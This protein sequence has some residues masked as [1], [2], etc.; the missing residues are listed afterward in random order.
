MEQAWIDASREAAKE[1]MEGVGAGHDF[2]HVCRVHANAAHLKSANEIRGI[3]IR[4]CVVE[5]AAWLHDVGD[6]KFHDGAELSGQLSEEIMSRVGVELAVRRAVVEIVDNISFRKRA[7]AKP[8]SLEG[9]LVQDA[10]RL[11]AVGAIGIVR[12][13]EYGHSKQQPFYVHGQS[14]Q[15]HSSLSEKTGVGHFFEKLFLLPELMNT[16][17]GRIEAERRVEFMHGFLKQ[18]FAE[19]TC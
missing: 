1:H 12:T 3:S 10:D 15:K 14:F 16:E 7:S 4:G 5:L 17:V 6:A 2:D 11:D 8:L 13:I 19:V 9:Q 18:F